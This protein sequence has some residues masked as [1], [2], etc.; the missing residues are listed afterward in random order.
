[1]A[2]RRP[3]VAT[4]AM[5]EVL[6]S[7]NARTYQQAFGSQATPTPTAN[8]TGN[9]TLLSYGSK[10]DAVRRLQARLVELGYLQSTVTGNYMNKTVEAVSKFQKAI[11]LSETGVATASLQEALFSSSAPRYN[12]STPTATPTNGLH[13]TE[14]WQHGSGR[15]GNATAIDRFGIPQRQ[16]GRLVL[17]GYG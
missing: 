7:D 11:G 4:E 17:S 1:M 10:G 3:G 9:Y 14:L 6:Y 5:Q 12:A 16:C 15:G 2:A 13:A 8:T